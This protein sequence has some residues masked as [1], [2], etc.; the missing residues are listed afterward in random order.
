VT[1]YAAKLLHDVVYVTLPEVGQEVKQM[2]AFGSLESIKAV[3]DIY[4]PLSGVVVEVN[5]E[6][7][8]RPELVNESPYRE[9]WIM[10]LK[11][12]SLEAERGNLLTAKAYAEYIQGLKK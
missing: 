7:E 5:R 12:S 9:G 3:A 1:D 2:E 11:P 4:S 10:V 6:L 8:D